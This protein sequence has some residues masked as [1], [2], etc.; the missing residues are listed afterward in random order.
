M[1]LVMVGIGYEVMINNSKREN[2]EERERGRVLLQVASVEDPLLDASALLERI[3][4]VQI[5]TEA[6]QILDTSEF[7]RN[8]FNTEVG[9]RLDASQL[10]INHHLRDG[11]RNKRTCQHFLRT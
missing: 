4:A 9:K 10:V 8:R 11:F 1:T 2:R 6:T 3:V 7:K 5:G